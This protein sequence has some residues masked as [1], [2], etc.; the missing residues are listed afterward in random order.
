MFCCRLQPVAS[1]VHQ[2]S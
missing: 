1:W 2:H